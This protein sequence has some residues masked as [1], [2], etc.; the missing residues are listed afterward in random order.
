MKKKH[1]KR[2]KVLSHV[3][4]NKTFFFIL[5]L[6]IF[7]FACAIVFFNRNETTPQFADESTNSSKKPSLD[8]N[9]QLTPEMCHATGDPVININEHIIHD[10][11]SGE[12]GN[13]WAFDTI[14]RHIQVWNVGL[15]NYCAVVRD[16]ASFQGVAGETSPGQTVLNATSLTGNEHG[17]FQGGYRTTVFNGTL[18]VQDQVNWPLKGMVKP[19]PVDYQCN[20]AGTCPGRIDWS[21][22][23]FKDITGYDLAWW[24]WIYQGQDSGTWVNAITGNSGDILDVDP[25]HTHPASDTSQALH[26]HPDKDK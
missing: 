16:L 20:I 14:N 1:S 19:D 17:I 5:F 9:T 8:F 15:N 13:N 12:A 22:K 23:Y 21:G 11:D 18:Y 10:V 24:G 6:S 7:F 2:K 3:S 25:T 4:N 26:H